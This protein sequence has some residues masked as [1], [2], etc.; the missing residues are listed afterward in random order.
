MVNSVSPS[1][2]GTAAVELNAPAARAH[3]DTVSRA[4][5]VSPWASNCPLRSMS[6]TSAAADSDRKFASTPLMRRAVSAWM[7]TSC[8]LI[9]HPL[10]SREPADH[11]HAGYCVESVEHALSS[12]CDGLEGRNTPSPPIQQEFQILD[13]R[14]VRQVSFVVL[15][16]VRGLVQVVLVLL[17][18]FL[19]V[20]EAVHVVAESVP[21]RVRN[22][23]DSVHSAQH[24]LARHVVVHLARHCVELEL[25]GE[26]PHRK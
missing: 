13:R 26:A 2:R 24:Q 14:D 16:D 9:P 7:A 17:E 10:L 18:V 20:T 3:S 4:R 12:D 25:G 5:V 11:Y 22:E 6:S 8:M 19:E 21:L 1:R 15:D 23:D